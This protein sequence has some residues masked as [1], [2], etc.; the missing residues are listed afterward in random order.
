MSAVPDIYMSAV[1]GRREFRAAYR[2]LRAVAKRIVEETP[3]RPTMQYLLVDSN[4]VEELARLLGTEIGLN[5]RR[6]S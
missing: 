4:L 2:E 1:K 3:A 5:S 6:Q